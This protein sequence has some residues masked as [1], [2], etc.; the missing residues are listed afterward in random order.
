MK[1]FYRAAMRYGSP[2]LFTISL[3]IVLM[4]ILEVYQTLEQSEALQGIR[5]AD[6][7]VL[8]RFKLLMTAVAKSLLL[9][10]LPFAGAVFVHRID[11]FLDQREPR[12]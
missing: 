11:R 3:I 6:F 9:A 10:A 4:S 1:S 7:G 5:L 2:I 8:V 12:E